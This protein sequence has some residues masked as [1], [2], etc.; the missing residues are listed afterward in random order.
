MAIT[1]WSAVRVLKRR[2]GLETDGREWLLAMMP[3]DSVCAEV[4]VNE[5]VFS[6][7]ILQLVHPE[8]L[9]LIDPWQFQS[10]PL[11]ASTLYG[12]EHGQNQGNMDARYSRVVKKFSGRR[13]VTMHRSGSLD[14]L[15]GFADDY[16]D[17]I[18]LEAITVMNA[19]SKNSGS[20]IAK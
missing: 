18:Y 17:W 11:F 8:M 15:N 3:K 1:V 5:G 4:G 12:G 14:C 2:I 19:L 6:R 7:R 9:H 20:F 13:N 10:D 16:F